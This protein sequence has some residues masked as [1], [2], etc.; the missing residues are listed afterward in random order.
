[1]SCIVDNSILAEGA[2]ALADGLRHVSQLQTLNLRGIS[3]I[4][5]PFF[6]VGREQ[7]YSQVWEQSDGRKTAWNLL[8]SISNLG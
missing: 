2:Q 8:L 3:L 4:I 5:T 7:L 6:D 1:M